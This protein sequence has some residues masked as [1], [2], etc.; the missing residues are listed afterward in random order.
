MSTFSVE[1]L[2]NSL[3]SYEKEFWT[4]IHDL[5]TDANRDWLLKKARQFTEQNLSIEVHFNAIME[6]FPES[7]SILL[8]LLLI[9]LRAENSKLSHNIHQ[10]LI[11]SMPLDFS[12]DIRLLLS[13]LINVEETTGSILRVNES[14]LINDVSSAIETLLTISKQPSSPPTRL[15][16]K[17]YKTSSRF[18]ELNQWFLANR[19]SSASEFADS[20]Y[21]QHLSGDIK[22]SEYC[23]YLRKLFRYINNDSELAVKVWQELFRYDFHQAV[24]DANY[25]RQLP[26][27]SLE[28]GLD[29][30]LLYE[31]NDVPDPHLSPE[32]RHGSEIAAWA[33]SPTLDTALQKLRMTKQYQLYG[34]PCRLTQLRLL[35]LS[36][37]YSGAPQSHLRNKIDS[38]A[39]IM[40]PLHQ[41]SSVD[42][43]E[44][45]SQFI[46]SSSDTVQVVRRG[47]LHFLNLAFESR[48]FKL[49][50]THQNFLTRFQTPLLPWQENAI[51]S[52]AAHGRQ[53][54]VMAATGTGKSRLGIAAILE[55]VQDSMPSL[56]LTHRLAIKGQWK[57]DELGAIPGRQDILGNTLKSDQMIFCVGKNVHELSSEDSPL[58]F[59]EL[60][61][62]DDAQVLLAL[63]KSLSKRM[64]SLPPTWKNGSL[65]IADEVHRFGESAGQEVLQGPFSRRL[66]L[67]ATLSYGGSD[68]NILNRFGETVIADYP[69]GQAISD[70][71]VNEYNLLVVRGHVQ[72]RS[73]VFGKQKV[74]LDLDNIQDFKSTQVL[75]SEALARLELT[76]T[77]LM[78]CLE[79]KHYEL[80]DDFELELNRIIQNRVPDLHKLAKKYLTNLNTYNRLSRKTENS[81]GFL[82]IVAPKI[83]EHG[84][85]L[86]FSNWREQGKW[87]ASKLRELDVKIEYL[88]GDSDYSQRNSAFERLSEISE[89]GSIDAI[90]APFILDEGVNIPQARIGVFMSNCPDGYRQ[91]VQRMGRVLRK[92]KNGEGRRALLL[93]TVGINT[94][95]DPGENGENQYWLD[96]MYGVMS[97]HASEVRIT[98]IDQAV[99][100]QNHLDDLL[101]D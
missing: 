39:S 57:K 22:T 51:E 14:L 86:I 29:T 65:L 71:V 58:N 7:E 11:E 92:G 30:L 61:S 98:S 100:I 68:I 91:I 36:I 42:A 78:A 32:I 45:V 10:F 99:A 56:I 53:G 21:Q 20:I 43:Y 88:D 75:M 31:A 5:P 54:I 94:R 24:K 67:T 72:E 18:D 9:E 95:E 84:K 34:K 74:V 41:S 19:E 73:N 89:S 38:A 15:L 13:S 79:S 80:F 4:R 25:Y 55:A 28:M 101:I 83:A 44:Y 63:D 93:L 26:P 23:L 1:V 50:E 8:L 66:G 46:K 16:L 59:D 60:D 49:S 37:E 96:T 62:K 6:S 52:W 40:C 3:R 33:I 35:A 85:T 76:H 97:E 64:N 81:E 70:G 69:I 90:V 2:L 17:L 48:R 77:E 27:S 12:F 87:I 47:T 82:D